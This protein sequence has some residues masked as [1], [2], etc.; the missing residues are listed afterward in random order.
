MENIEMRR[1]SSA[2]W[3]DKTKIEIQSMMVTELN[4]NDDASKVSTLEQQEFNQNANEE[5]F[6]VIKLK[7][8]DL[9]VVD[10]KSD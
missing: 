4:E 9:L 7:E 6:H 2:S 10:V 5:E 8:F 1:M 3:N